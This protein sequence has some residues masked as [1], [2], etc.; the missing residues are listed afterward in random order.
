[1]GKF[2]ILKMN[3]KCLRPPLPPHT[4][5]QEL[6]ETLY[7]DVYIF[8]IDKRWANAYVWKSFMVKFFL[9]I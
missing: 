1:M 5:A 4:G 7:F 9:Q 8:Y 6:S 3:V 2:T